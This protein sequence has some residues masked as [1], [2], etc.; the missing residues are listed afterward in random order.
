MHRV[1]EEARR[2]LVSRGSAEGAEKTRR[3]FREP[4]ATYGCTSGDA[5]AVARELG[6]MLKRDLG[7]TFTVA[8]ELLRGDVLEE[9][10]VAVALLA[11]VKRRLTAEHMDQLD[12]WISCLT[13][14]ASVDSF[15]T[16]VVGALM[17]REPGFLERLRGWTA[18]PSRWRRRAAAVSLVPAARRGAMLHDVLCVADLMMEDRD[19]MVQK[20]VGWLLKEASKLHRCEVREYLLG[21][22]DRAPAL[23]LRYASEKL[24]P[25]QRVLKTRA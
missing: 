15:C 25:G 22:R 7:Q 23:V 6:P 20:G 18:S 24:P 9:Q 11:K 21:W 5:T 10:L 12:E 16:R 8:G 3:Y 1:S 17:E 13:N 14:W 2:R 19:D 4:V